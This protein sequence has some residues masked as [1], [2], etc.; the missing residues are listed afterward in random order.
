MSTTMTQSEPGLQPRGE[1][2]S[3]PFSWGRQML[4]KVPEITLYY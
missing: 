2:S 1:K 4:N 3:A